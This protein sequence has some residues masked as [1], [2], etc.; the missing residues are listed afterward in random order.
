MEKNQELIKSYIEGQ[1]SEI[2]R[3]AFDN[4]LATDPEL[5][6]E[7]Q[8]F[9]D[10]KTVVQNKDVFDLKQKLREIVENTP[11]EPDFSADFDADFS[12]DFAEKAPNTEGASFSKISRR[13]SF[14]AAAV[15]V[16]AAIAAFFWFRNQEVKRL[17]N[18][19]QTVDFQ[20]FEN[21]I[22]F[23]ST[24]TRPLA[25]ALQAYNRQAYADAEPL[26]VRHLKS[27]PTD[28]EATFYLGMCQALT[29]HFDLATQAF[30]QAAKATNNPLTKPAQWYLAL[31]YLR[32]GA[33]DKARPLLESLKTDAFFGDKAKQVLEKVDNIN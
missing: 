6:A 31:C 21:T 16:L 30:E 8:L 17:Q 29:G 2:D 19:A 11:I 25:Q 15:I 28:K 10:L 24:D 3:L 33:A 14:T 13:T 22:Q 26:F 18:I 1:L 12:A 9:R 27:N 20:P 7:V 4:A 5:A 23:D 32:T